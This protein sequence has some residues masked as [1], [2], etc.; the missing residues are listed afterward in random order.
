MEIRFDGKRALVT[1]AGKGIGRDIAKALHKCGADTVALSR[2]QAD[3]DSL[4]QECPGIQTV[5]Q[6]LSDWNK[7]RHVL[8]GLGHVDLLV[9]NAGVGQLVSF[10]ECTEELL[11]TSFGIN[12][13][14]LFNVSQEAG[15]FQQDPREQR[16]SHT[17]E[18]RESPACLEQSH[19]RWLSTGVDTTGRI[20]RTASQNSFM[21]EN[22]GSVL[23]EDRVIM[24]FQKLVD[25]SERAAAFF[26]SQLDENGSLKSQEVAQEL[27]AMYKLPTLLVLTGRGRLAHKLLNNIKKRFMQEDGD[28]LSYPD[29]AG[30]ARK[31]ANLE[32]QEYWPYMNCW[33]AMAAHRLARFDISVPAWRFLARYFNPE[34]GGFGT[35]GRYDV[36]PTMDD[37]PVLWSGG[38]HY[39]VGIFMSSHLGLFALF[40]GDLEKATKTGDLMVRMVAQQPA[41]DQYF[42]LH[43]RGDSGELIQ[44][45]FPEGRRRYYRLER[46]EPKELYYQL[47]YPV[48]FLHHLYTVIGEKKYLEA[49]EK[50]L[51][52][53]LSCDE[54]FFSFF[55][56]HKVA[57]G[58]GLVA[59]TTGKAKYRE[60][61]ARC[62]K[63]LLS[64]QTSEGDFL[65]EI[66]L[67]PSLD[68]TAEIPIWCR[69]LANNLVDKDTL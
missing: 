34:V 47:G 28:F 55:L 21:M 19:D 49:G 51:D 40:M 12:F 39:D 25:C 61:C 8:R 50:I 54:S 66:G 5:T 18:D 30:N 68:Q 37:G 9:N 24:E 10:L 64:L 7:A 53:A 27:G 29:K 42:V 59:M 48:Y 46:K 43:V 6:D 69:D 41:L 23:D 11:D 22:G 32:I 1:G 26:E 15:P 58:A 14:G 36:T 3:L 57:Y 62:V 67:Q 35:S 13:K 16:V 56:N 45:G 60:M 38:P 63:Y 44:E 2:T 65:R 33:V 31:T 20:S 52:F 4:Q 17:G